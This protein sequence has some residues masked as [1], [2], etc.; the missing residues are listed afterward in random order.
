MKSHT[1]RAR[2]RHFRITRFKYAGYLKEIFQ[3]IVAWIIGV[4]VYTLIL[5]LTFHEVGVLK[6]NGLEWLFFALAIGFMIG[7]IN[8]LFEVFLFKRI[9][10]KMKFIYIVVNKTLFLLIAFIITVTLYVFFKKYILIPLGIA[11]SM[12]YD[13]L[14]DVFAS[15][16]IQKHA[17]I[18]IMINF[19][20]NFFMMVKK[21]MG[22]GV[23]LNLFLGKYHRPRQEKRIVMFL[24]LTS[25]TAIAEKLDLY[26]YSSF[27]KDFFFDIDG[28]IEDSKGAVFQFVGDEVVILWDISDGCENNNCIKFFFD[29]QDRIKKFESNYLSKYGIIPDFKAGLHYGTVVITEVGGSKQEIAYH[30]DAVNTTARI[31]S[32]CN[33]V[34]KKLLVS[35]ELVSQMQELDRRY[36]IE[37]VGVKS[38]KGKENVV[39][40]FSIEKRAH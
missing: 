16:E 21:M 38:F 36:I 39:A 26:K 34:G 40:L 22:K 28:A 9:F 32:E 27:L 3:F 29:A 15:S 35:A 23:L 13:S 17:L 10:R 7:S 20:I 5:V 30:G 12:T 14:L 2:L 31:R 25:S 11:D 1:F 37:S 8:G 19:S 24:D 33:S 4:S 6:Y 18:A